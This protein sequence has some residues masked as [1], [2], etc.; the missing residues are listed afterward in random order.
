MFYSK[1]Y[2]SNILYTMIIIGFKNRTFFIADG[3][4][5][6]LIYTVVCKLADKSI[7]Y[8]LSKRRKK[9]LPPS[10]TSSKVSHD[11]AREAIDCFC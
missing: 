10:T 11:L 4:L 8:F 2:S 1:I 6:L 7:N 5:M 9:K 3:W